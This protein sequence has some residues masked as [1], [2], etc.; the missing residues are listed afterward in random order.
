MKYIDVT[1]TTH[2]SLDVPLEKQIDDFCNVDEGLYKIHFTKRKD[3]WRDWRRNKQD[4]TM[5]GR[6]CGSMCLR[7]RKA[8]QAWLSRNQNLIMQDNHVS[9]SLNLKTKN[10]STSSKTLV[11]SWK[12]RCQ[13]QCFAKHSCRSTEKSK[14]KYARIV[15]ADESMRIRFEGVP[16]NYYEDHIS[17]KWMNS[18]SRKHLVHNFIPMPQALEIPDTKTTVEK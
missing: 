14:T 10:S 9:F 7:Q 18:L 8:K 5:N 6:M 3:T 16:H 12:F 4:P 2:T 13:Q 11:G 17:A 1:R 15:N